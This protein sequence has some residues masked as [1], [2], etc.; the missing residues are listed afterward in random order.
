MFEK[1]MWV[2]FAHCIGDFALQTEYIVKNKGKWTG[3]LVAHCFI[4]MGCMAVA[5]KYVGWYSDALMLYFFFTHLIID[6]LKCR[7]I[8]HLGYCESKEY[9]LAW[10]FWL[11][12]SFHLVCLYFV[13]GV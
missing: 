13:R 2:L 8:S 4:Y 3:F 12:Q 10:A 6:S 9:N 7:F 5:F 1:M 11:D